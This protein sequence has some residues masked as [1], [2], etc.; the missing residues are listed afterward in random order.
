MEQ[1]GLHPLQRLFAL[2]EQIDGFVV[3]LQR[4]RALQRNGEPASNELPRGL[5]KVVSGQSNDLEKVVQVPALQ[6][7]V[8]K[9]S[10]PILK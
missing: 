9:I 5:G 6:R 10:A 8:L 3:C 7:E 4:L 1:P 2:S